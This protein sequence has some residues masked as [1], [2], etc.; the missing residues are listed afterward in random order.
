MV[1]GADVSF[2][3][4]RMAVWCLV[5]GS[6]CLVELSASRFMTRIRMDF[7]MLLANQCRIPRHHSLSLSRMTDHPILIACHIRNLKITGT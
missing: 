4:S 6:A 1:G 7:A 2:F 3:S 5:Y